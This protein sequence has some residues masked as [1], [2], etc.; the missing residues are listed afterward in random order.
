[1]YLLV[2]INPNDML[3]MSSTPCTRM[4]CTLIQKHAVFTYEIC[5][6]YNIYHKCEICPT[7]EICEICSIYDI[8]NIW[9]PE[10]A[11]LPPPMFA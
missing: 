8:C 7:C 4:L 1:M 6:T 9:V 11:I 10:L 3:K 5:H 2:R